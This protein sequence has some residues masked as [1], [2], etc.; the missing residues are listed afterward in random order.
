MRR[1][2]HSEKSL[3]WAAALWAVFLVGQVHNAVAHHR[4]PHEASND[5]P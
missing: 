1:L 2:T 5:A 3:M 4:P